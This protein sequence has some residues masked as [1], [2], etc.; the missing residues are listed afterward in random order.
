MRCIAVHGLLESL[1]LPVRGRTMFSNTLKISD[2][3]PELWAA[4]QAQDLRQEE[5]I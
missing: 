5:H 3:D 2:F 4:N 1:D